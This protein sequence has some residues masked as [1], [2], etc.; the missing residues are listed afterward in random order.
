MREVSLAVSRSDELRTAAERGDY[1][2]A[3]VV[4]Q[5]L[6][7]GMEAQ[8][9]QFRNQME[10]YEATRAQ[11]DWRRALRALADARIAAIAA[12]LPELESVVTDRLYDVVKERQA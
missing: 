10:V 7:P 3:A 1:A 8:L 5:Q 6:A 4:A 11:A 9:G 2:R 12:G